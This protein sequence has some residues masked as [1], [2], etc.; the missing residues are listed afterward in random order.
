MDVG[1]RAVS[2]FDDFNVLDAIGNS[3]Q[4]RTYTASNTE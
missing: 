1:S 2:S 3:L 4:G